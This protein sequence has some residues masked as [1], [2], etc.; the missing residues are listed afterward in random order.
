MTHG[1]T[2]PALL[3]NLTER[4]NIRIHR[5][6]VPLSEGTRTRP[7]SNSSNQRKLTDRERHIGNEFSCTIDGDGPSQMRIGTWN[8]WGIADSKDGDTNAKRKE[9][10]NF[11]DENEKKGQRYELMFIQETW[12]AGNDEL[13]IDGYKWIGRNRTKVDPDAPRN[14]G[15]SGVLVHESISHLVSI[16]K[17]PTYGGTEGVIWIKVEHGRSNRFD[18]FCSL[19]LE[20]QRQRFK[21]D[22]QL[23]FEGIRNDWDKYTTSAFN[24]FIVGDFNT[25]VG[26]LQESNTTGPRDGE[27]IRPNAQARELVKRLEE[28]NAAII[29]GRKCEWNYTYKPNDKRALWDHESVCDYMVMKDNRFAHINECGIDDT[30]DIASDHNLLWI[31]LDYHYEKATPRARYNSKSEFRYRTAQLRDPETLARFHGAVKREMS[32]WRSGVQNNTHPT[33]D[34]IE[35]AWAGWR[36]AMKQAATTTIGTRRL[37]LN[38]PARNFEPWWNPTLTALV[39]HRTEIRT[40]LVR[41][42]A[43]SKSNPTRATRYAQLCHEHNVARKAVKDACRNARHAWQDTKL[44][45]VETL[46]KSQPKKAWQEVNLMA[47]KKKSTGVG[48]IR[49]TDGQ[50]TFDTAKKLNIFAR[51]YAKLGKDEIP[52]GASYDMIHRDAVMRDVEHL[53]QRPVV[54]ENTP[55][56]AE[57]SANEIRKEIAKQKDNACSPL[58]RITNS[59]LVA[60]GDAVID[61]LVVLFALIFKSG[62]SPKQWQQGVMTM[63]PKTGDLTDWA[64]YRGITLLSIVGKVFEG[65]M[66]NRIFIQLESTG[67]L[68]MEQGGFRKGYG[69]SDHMFVLAETIK[70]RARRN[71]ST[72]C[73]FLDIRKAYPTMWRGGMLHA[74]AKAGIGGRMWRMVDRMYAS[75]KTQITMDGQMSTEYAVESGLREGSVLSPILYSAFINGAIAELQ[76]KTPECGVELEAGLRIRVLMYADDIV[77]VAKSPEHL[78]RMLDV[79]EKHA[80]K[81]QYQFSV[82]KRDAQNKVTT[83]GK[84]EIVIFG[85][86]GIT[87]DTFSLHGVQLEQKRSYKYLGVIMHQL[88]GKHNGTEEVYPHDYKGMIFFDDDHNELR[89]INEIRHDDTTDSWMA[90]TVMCDDEGNTKRRPESHEYH[91]NNSQTKMDAMIR[92]ASAM[93]QNGIKPPSDT[94]AWD[95]HVRS[96]IEKLN[97]QQWVLRRMQCKCGGFSPAIARDLMYA[98]TEG[99]T[100]YACEIWNTSKTAWTELE[101]ACAKMHQR[102]LGCQN[103]TTLIAMRSE[104]DATSQRGQRDKGSLRFLHRI[105][106]METNRL[107]P[108]MLRCIER[109]AKRSRGAKENWATVTMPTVLSKYDLT[110]PNPQLSKAQWKKEVNEAIAA[111]ETEQIAKAKLSE[112][113]LEEYA[114]L[115]SVTGMPRYLKQRRTWA[116]TRGRSIKT[117]LRCGTTELELERGRYTYPVTPREARTCKCCNRNEIE[118]S[119]HFVMKCPLFAQERQQF[120]Q[121]IKADIVASKD[122]YNW[123]RKTMRQKWEFLL[124][125]GPSVQE[126]SRANRQ[127][128]KMETSLYHYLATTY[129]KRRDHLKSG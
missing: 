19:Y 28:M 66:A 75:T 48:A 59:M 99:S 84:S 54:S 93:L 82:P 58:D 52:Q 55:L 65:V 112:S 18:V 47:G 118:D 101:S 122:Y 106:K 70:H 2:T 74:L 23:I 6:P 22:N 107:A 91:L 121:E 100:N 10:Q 126:S 92:R 11:M 17:K 9:L 50:I 30:S 95:M 90:T 13:E 85:E 117:K 110:W 4:L 68:P 69:C 5:T 45:N 81:G 128:G 80:N 78:Q 20:Q 125:D 56:N 124:G 61:S 36:N 72:Y 34:R 115:N 64:N 53:R 88:L 32:Q 94:T 123:Q 86:N 96:K 87:T 35:E 98:I 77:L 39:K 120:M 7:E 114:K 49:D 89:R 26:K 79:M 57:F 103:K 83:S 42:R 109:D 116:M 3:A 104:L 97:K 31:A 38:A 105:T 1:A 37:R 67:K 63:I 46:L 41:A 15:G 44:A 21:T 12:F 113:K 62:T 71:L 76:D 29:H 51:E 127:W 73:A 40:Q 60:G 43:F 102:I 24:A 27:N 16:I 25:R 8:V 129:K 33:Q 14:S 108:R 111:K 119:Y